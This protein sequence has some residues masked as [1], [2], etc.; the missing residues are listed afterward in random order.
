MRTAI[1][2][3]NQQPAD[4]AFSPQSGEI[5]ESWAFIYVR[6]G[7]D[8]TADRFETERSGVRTT[9]VAVPEQAAAVQTAIDLVRSGVQVI[10]LC[11]ILGP[12]WAARVIEA[13]G[14]RVPVGA[15]TYGAES[16][17]LFLSWTPA[18][19]ASCGESVCR[20]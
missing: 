18:D 14:G 15:V 10:E 3:L 6:P 17:A 11:S 13:T 19:G 2:D 4:E 16:V 5:A 12:T 20:E 7:A 9:L 1:S 8:P